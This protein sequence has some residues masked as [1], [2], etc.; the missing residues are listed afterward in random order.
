[1]GEIVQSNLCPVLSSTSGG[2][3]RPRFKASQLCDPALSGKAAFIG[4]IFKVA[5]FVQFVNVNKC[6]SVTHVMNVFENKGEY[7]RQTTDGG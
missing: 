6:H 7:G 5:S 4:A 1:M 3:D 2:Y